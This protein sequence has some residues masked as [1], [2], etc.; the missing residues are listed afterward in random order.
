MPS[1][2]RAGSDRPVSNRSGSEHPGG[3][4]VAPDGSPSESAP[5][6]EEDIPASA[7]EA[8]VS[9]D[10]L[11]LVLEHGQSMRGDTHRFSVTAD[12]EDAYS[13]VSIGILHDYKI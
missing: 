3:S 6:V 4:D 5:M 12:P 1:G 7:V 9:L 13:R 11:M 8:L 2:S 10:A